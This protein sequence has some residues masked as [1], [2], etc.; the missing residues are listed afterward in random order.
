[1]TESKPNLVTGGLLG[2]VASRV[3]DQATT[4][5]YER[6]SDASKRR[7]QE[8]APGG[9]L[10]QLGKQLGEAAGRELDDRAAGRA[11][12]AVHRTLGVGYGAAAVA[13]VRRGVSPMSAG[14]AVGGAAFLVVDEGLSMS[15]LFDY[16]LESHLRGVIGHAAFGLT[17]GCLL[18]A[19]SRR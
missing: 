7:E 18:W 10:V 1:V 12:L 17:A 5:F 19:A 13:L 15:E 3:M 11:G 6:Q 2:Y 9:T 16:P 4:A 14:L 8:L